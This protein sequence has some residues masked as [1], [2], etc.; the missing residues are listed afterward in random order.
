MPG[1]TAA[2]TQTTTIASPNCECISSPWVLLSV[3]ELLGTIIASLMTFSSDCRKLFEMNVSGR[4]P[5]ALFHLTNLVNLYIDSSGLSGPLPSGLTNMMSLKTLGVHMS[6]LYCRWAFD[7]DFT[8][9]LP[10]SIGQLTNL[11]DL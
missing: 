4:I 9:N 11:T 8:G 1:S 7:N 6:F 10:E 3:I 5:D 2:A